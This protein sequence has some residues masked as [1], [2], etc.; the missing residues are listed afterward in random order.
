MCVSLDFG[1][2]L[3][4]LLGSPEMTCNL[5]CTPGR[6]CVCAPGEDDIGCVWVYRQ[7]V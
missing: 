6:P 3:D 4:G 7:D 2:G 1:Y 5:V